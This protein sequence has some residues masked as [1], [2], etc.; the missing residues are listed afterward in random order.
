AV[1]TSN[2]QGVAPK[3]AAREFSENRVQNDSGNKA[4][5]P[6]TGPLAATVPGVL[7]A[8]IVALDNFG[9][10]K[11]ADVLQ[12]AIELADGF[13]ID[14]MRVN[15]IHNTR[16]IFEQWPEARAI[17]LPNGQEPKVGDV[18]VQ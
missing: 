18:F 11:L 10:L 9:T 13:P 4:E 16:Q 7:D 2:V 14:E 17:F 5:I 8:M 12:P 15:Y 6:S 1:T 3:L